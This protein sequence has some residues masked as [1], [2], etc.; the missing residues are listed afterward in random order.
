MLHLKVYYLVTN[1]FLNVFI[2]IHRC[3]YRAFNNMFMASKLHLS[4]SSLSIP[5]SSS[6]CTCISTENSDLLNKT[7][8]VPDHWML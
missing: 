7:K 6:L 8:N 1:Q 3:K 5:K 2:R 4:F